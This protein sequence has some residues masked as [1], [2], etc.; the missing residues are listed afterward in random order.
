[1]RRRIPEATVRRTQLRGKPTLC[2]GLLLS[3]ALAGCNRE[4]PTGPSPAETRIARLGRSY[5]IYSGQNKGRPPK[6]LDELRRYVAARTTADDMAAMGVSSV[7][8][9]FVSPRDGEAYKLIVLPR[10]PPPVAGEPGP[11]VIYEH[12]GRGGMRWVA[13]LGGATEEV[14][15]HK[16]QQ[17]VALAK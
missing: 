13:Y 2:C 14:D 4:Q 11:V 12:S 9:L 15:E 5:A 17:L 1:M 3:L 10:L 8:E 16:F 6:S 7:D